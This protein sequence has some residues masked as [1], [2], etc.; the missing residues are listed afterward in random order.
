MCLLFD[1][2]IS[3]SAPALFSWLS[4]TLWI[5]SKFYK[6]PLIS[7]SPCLQMYVHIFVLSISIS[8]SH[9]TL[10]L[11]VQASC[12]FW[13]I[14]TL[15]SQRHDTRSF[16]HLESSPYTCMYLLRDGPKDPSEIVLPVRCS[17]TLSIMLLLFC[18]SIYQEL[19]EYHAL[20]L[21]LLFF[22]L[23]RPECK[24]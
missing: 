8:P 10:T 13:Y 23:S 18:P 24:L 5:K 20:L 14:A 19:K 4:F 21:C 7:Q 11:A 15:E 6:R 3:L 22:F 12:W 16:L 2:N 17:R 9:L 1:H